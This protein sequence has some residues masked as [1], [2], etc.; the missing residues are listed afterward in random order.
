MAEDVNPINIGNINDGA[1]IDAFNIELRKILDNIADVNTPATDTRTM[2]LQIAFRP[3]ADRCTI[4]TELKTSAKLAG[5]EKHSARIFAGRSEDG[6]VV[7]FDKDPRQMP[8]W[9]APKP[10]ETPVVQFK[11]AKE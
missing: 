1:V 11:T 6:V 7:A 3:H 5:L 9:S 4:V 8:L 10:K 2:T